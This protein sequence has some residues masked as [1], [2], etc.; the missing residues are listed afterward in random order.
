MTF[1]KTN[2]PAVTSAAH[3][4]SLRSIFFLPRH[5]FTRPDPLR[6]WNRLYSYKLK[7]K[8]YPFLLRNFPP[9]F[10]MYLQCKLH[11]SLFAVSGL[12]FSEPFA[13][14]RGENSS[15]RATSK[16]ANFLESQIK[17]NR[18]I[19]FDYKRRIM[20]LSCYS[21]SVKTGRTI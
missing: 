9:A 15:S 3:Y 2:C 5:N 1:T 18:L 8:A 17:Y 19:R 10:T 16:T 7:R 6:A 21:S 12:S 11:K 14:F 13:F 20:R 4:P